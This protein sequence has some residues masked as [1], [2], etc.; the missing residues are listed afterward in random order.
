[1]QADELGLPHHHHHARPAE[2]LDGLGKRPRAV[3]AGD[4]PACST[5]TRSPRA[6]PCDQQSACITGGAG[7]I[8]S[9]LA[10]RLMRLRRRGRDPRRLPHRP[11]RVPRR[12]ACERRG[13]RCIEG[14]VLDSAM[15]ERAFEGCDWVFHLQANADVRRGPGASAARP[16]AEHDRHRRTCS[17]RC[18]RRASGRSCSPPPARST[19]SPTCSRRP[20]TRPSRSRPR[21][22]RPPSSPARG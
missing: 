11:A 4:R 10:D 3:L 22:T 13:A 17:R 2:K 12:A 16:R 20:R 9:N 5:T 15:L 14:D 7:F 6:S 19:A 8:G 21:C 1:M 18:A